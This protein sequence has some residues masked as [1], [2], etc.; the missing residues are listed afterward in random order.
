MSMQPQMMLM[1]K[2][3]QIITTDLV[4]WLDAGM[5][6][7]YPG[8]GTTWTDLSPEGNDVTFVNTP[9]FSSANGG[10]LDFDGTNDHGTLDSTTS[11]PTGAAA[12]TI[13][14]WVTVDANP[15]TYG[16][17]LSYG[18]AATGQARSLLV[19]S[20]GNF[21][22][23]GFGASVTS[24][25]TATL[26]TWYNLA[27]TYDGTNSELFINGASDVVAARTLNTVLSIRKIGQFLDAAGE[28]WNGKVAMILHYDVELTATQIDY[29]YDVTKARFA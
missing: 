6:N 23:S 14:A 22:G 8:S 12:G 10:H 2:R 9:T 3:D 1:G 7:S 15:S 5:T 17:V 20:S 18:T 16:G 24:T 19:N 26:G 27:F 13:Q 4:L 21:I 29:N 28:Y 11:F 25:I